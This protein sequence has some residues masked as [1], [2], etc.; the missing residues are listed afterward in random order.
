MQVLVTGGTGFV[1]ERLIRA[2]LD[3]ANAGAGEPIDRI[4]CLARRP[5][6]IDHPQLSSVCADLCDR[7]AL[8]A[9]FPSQIDAVVHLAAVVS[10]SAEADFD[11]GMRVN[12]E[13]TRTLL[14]SLRASGRRPRFVFASSLAVFGGEGLGRVDGGRTPEPRSS[15]GIQ[16]LIGELLVE[17]YTRK[18]FIDGFSLRL[19]TIAIRPGAPN[20]SASGFVSAI[21]REPLAGRP[22]VLPV[23]AEQAVW[24]QSPRAAVANLLRALTMPAM[25]WSGRR[26]LTLPGLTVKMADALDTLEQIAGPAARALVDI[27]LD[28][29][30]CRIV[31]AWPAAFDTPRALAMGF[32]GDQSFESMVRAYIEDHPAAVGPGTPISQSH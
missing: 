4:W 3:P 13:G 17:D 16:K 9:A 12:V 28:P 20:G 21:I 19:P 10:G 29:A 30:L 22:A 26:S 24:V 8:D 31:Q 2:L 18:G 1:G 32:R 6:G 15:Y 5:L 7:A 11:L 14:D 27:R 23:P 25:D